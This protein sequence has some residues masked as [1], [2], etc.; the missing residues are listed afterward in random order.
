[1][2]AGQSTINPLKDARWDSLV[3][4][5]P[6]GT[7]YHHSSWL[8][9]IATT[10]RQATPVCFVLESEG[11]LSAALPACVVRSRLTHNRLV[12]LPFTPYCNPLVQSAAE[13]DALL[14]AAIGSLTRCEATF[15]ELRTLGD[16]PDSAGLLKKHAYHMTHIL[17]LEGGFDRVRKGISSNITTNRKKADKAGIRVRVAS[18]ESD[19]KAFYRVHAITRKKQGFPI[20]PFSFFRNMQDIMGP[21]GFVRILLAELNGSVIAGIVLFLYKNTVSYEI[22]ASLP[23]HLESRPNHLLLWEAVKS[24]CEEGRTEFDFGKSPPDNP[25]LVEFKRRWGAEARACPYYYFPEIRGLM[26]VEQNSLKHRAIRFL[27]RQSPLAVAQLL[28]RGIYRHLG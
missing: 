11:A 19:L 5:H 14:Q 18:T 27:Y 10:Y 1:M 21:P 4:G 17:D 28:G 15:Y 7:L 8:K 2:E 13:C 24:A 3:A 9:V 26:A 20:Q 12:S 23:E 22:G 25:G 16:I 6:G